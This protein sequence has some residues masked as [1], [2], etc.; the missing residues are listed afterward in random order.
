MNSLEPMD[1]I[2]EEHLGDVLAACLEAV[3]N[4][5]DPREATSRY[6]DFARELERFF[7]TQ[8]ELKRFTTPFETP[9]ECANAPGAVPLACADHLAAGRLGDFR[10]LREIGCGGMGV[11]YEAEQLSLKRQVALKVLPVGAALDARQLQRFTNEAQAAA[12]LHQDHIVPVH[13]VGCEQ[14]IHF[15]AMQFIAGPTLAEVIRELRE[16]NDRRPLR[17]DTGA[18][19]GNTLPPS[20]RARTTEASVAGRAFFRQA[21]EWGRQVAEALDYAHQH[22]VIHRDIK[23]ANLLLDADGKVWVTDFGLALLHQTTGPTIT[24]DLV[25]TLR[26]MS[27]EQALAKRDLVDHR[28]DVYSLGA[29]L[30]ELVALRPPFWANDRQELLRQVAFEEPRPPR[31]VNRAMPADLETIVLKAMA[32]D[33]AE[34][35]QTAQEFAD[36]LGHFLDD[37]PIL[38]RRATCIQRLARWSRRHKPLLATAGLGLI[39]ALLVSAAASW[40]AYQTEAQNSLLAATTLNKVLLELPEKQFLRSPRQKAEEAMLFKEGIA[41]Y[42]RWVRTVADDPRSLP[43]KASAYARLAGLYDRVGQTHEAETAYRKAAGLLER[44]SADSGEIAHRQDLATVLNNLGSL[45]EQRRRF[46]EAETFHRRSCDLCQELVAGSPDVPKNRQNLAESLTNLGL[47]LVKT[48]RLDEGEQVLRKAVKCLEALAAEFPA[49]DKYRADVAVTD[50]HLAVLL[51]KRKSNRQAEALLV[52]SQKVLQEVVARS[53]HPIYTVQLGH[54]YHQLGLVRQTGGRAA[55]AAAAYREAIKLERRVTAEFGWI[56]KFR[57]ELAV[58]LLKLG[59]VL[60]DLGQRTDA[61]AA[62]RE[63]LGLAD[64]VNG[65]NPDKPV[66]REVLA[67]GRLSLG[68]ILADSGRFEEAET[69]LRQ[70]VCDWQDLITDVAASPD[71]RKQ[72]AAAHMELGRFLAERGRPDAADVCYRDAADQWTRLRADLPKEPAYRQAASVVQCRRGLLLQAVGRLEEAEQS[73]RQAVALT[74]QLVAEFPVYGHYRRARAVAHSQLAALLAATSRHQE[75]EAAF[76]EALALA[77]DLVKGSPRAPTL[78]EDLAVVQDQWG[79]WLMERNLATEAEP[80]FRQAVAVLQ[81]LVSEQPVQGTYARKLAWLLAT[82]R[83]PA[84]H[85]A[86]RAVALARQAAERE[87]QDNA[88][89]IVLGA[90]YGR[91]GDWTSALAAL[92][93]GI[94]LPGAGDATDRFWLALAHARLGRPDLARRNYATAVSWMDTNRPRDPELRLLKAEV[95][96]ILELGPRHGRTERFDS[97]AEK[98]SR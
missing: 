61:E 52:Q 83:H 81:H 78:R 14:G 31:H 35:Y 73:V 32:K 60:A 86:T 63:A 50:N 41:F 3:E 27:P 53:Y 37:R 91:A 92:Q 44:A 77:T 68:R 23:P 20:D 57:Q 26:Y 6:P 21:A 33:P 56:P 72:R 15:Y 19:S 12:R 17:P 1:V 42:E 18:P 64:Q 47:V 84:I 82:C 46:A 16:R 39:V 75:T 7:A 87:S 8:G 9:G 11:V 13:A 34:R 93:R 45:C 76:R 71:H 66:G 97:T 24:G 58:T 10:I 40:H 38:A 69:N 67:G 94:S 29:T 74:D 96:A 30:Y 85:D 51:W 48:G 2:R 5:A 55:E 98:A 79:R 4:G 89:W 43:V 28:T 95:V 70:T 62:L 54:T 36:D 25:G 88:I 22:G 59:E 65:E 80:H 49:E 90:A